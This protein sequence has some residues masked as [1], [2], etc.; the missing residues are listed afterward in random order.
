VEREEEREKEG[1]HEKMKGL[2]SNIGGWKQQSFSLYGDTVW[3]ILCLGG[4]ATL[5]LFFDR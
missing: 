5:T 2:I 4:L 3:L 1:K